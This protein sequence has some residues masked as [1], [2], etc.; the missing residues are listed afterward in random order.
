M[1]LRNKQ[2][3]IAVTG[4]IAAYKTA[5]LVREVQAEGAQ[6]RVVMTASATSFVAAKT[7]QALSGNPVAITDNGLFDQAG[8][9]HIALA[10]W[11]DLIVIAPASANSIAKLVHGEADELLYSMCLAHEGQVAIAPAMN[12]QM[13]SNAATQENLTR[14]RNRGFLIW[15]P[16]DGAQACGEVGP[17]RML[18]VAELLQLVVSTF[19][20]TAFAGQHIVIT[21]GPTH[22]AIDPVRYIGNR[23]SGKMGFALAEAALAAGARV[24]LVAGPTEQTCSPRIHIINVETA[25][26]M[27]LAVFQ[28]LDDCDLFIA[29]AAVADYRVANI[30]AEKIKK[31]SEHLSLELEPTEDILRDVKQ[32][33][34]ELFCVGFAAETE[35]T[36]EYA[37]DK[38]TRKKLDMI[39]ANQVGSSEQGFSSDYNAV[40]ILTA[41]NQE[42]IARMRKTALAPK[43]LDAI[44]QQ[45]LNRKENSNVRY[46]KKPHST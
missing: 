38:L 37:R 43:I 32:A 1:T 45:L 26:E 2:I 25:A 39:I 44:H 33:Q 23:S 42:S 40:E 14:L 16:A 22:E 24:T 12:Q 11:A 36:I 6:V 20:N 27:H 3:V 34:P 18:E 8:M 35:H 4:G 29:C 30:A 46:L 5:Q 17:G 7:F 19:E 21:A 15:G 31:R 41:D 13:W 28:Q 10:R 9:D